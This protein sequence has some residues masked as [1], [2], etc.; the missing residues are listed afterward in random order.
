MSLLADLATLSKSSGFRK[1]LG[2]R[3][4]SQV[5]DGMFQAGMASLFFF[6]SQ[7]MTSAA[8][9]ASALVVMLGPYSLVG[10][11]FGPLL[12]RWRRRQILL[13]GNAM[14]CIVGICVAVATWGPTRIEIVYALTLCMLGL[15]RFLLAA[16]SAGL[17]SVV[18][19]RELLAANSVVPTVG[20]FATGIGIVIGFLLRAFLPEGFSRNIASLLVAAI[21]Y[22]GAAGAARLLGPDQLGP[23]SKPE[24]ADEF[25]PVSALEQTGELRSVGEHPTE[26]EPTSSAGSPASLRSSVREL[27]EAVIYVVRRRTPGLALAVMAFHRFVYEMEFIT[28]IL[29]SRNLLADPA[30]A[31]AGLAYFGALGGA[32]VAG[33]FVAVVLTP[34]AHQKIVPWRWVVTSLVAGSVGQALFVAGPRFGA[35][36]AGAFAVGFGVQGAKIAVDTIVQSDTFDAYR[37]RASAIYDLLF[38]LGVCAAAGVSLFAL[39]DIGWSRP[40]QTVLFGLVWVVT[41]GFYWAMVRLGGCPQVR[42]GRCP[43]AV[44]C[45]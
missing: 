24:S 41:F 33:Q 40:V 20:G 6:S 19:A 12:D 21:L 34:L 32:M 1:L 39:P 42:L 5:G 3:L 30:D 4:I 14:R 15:S 31:D 27:A 10:P 25:A 16:L 26:S 23:A 35:M 2:V 9:I 8:G 11:L 45:E 7:F 28:I 36:A 37:G 18:G 44:D 29:V 38:N 22:A 13:W 43:R 17:P